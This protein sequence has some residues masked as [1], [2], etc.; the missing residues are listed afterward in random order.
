MKFVRLPILFSIILALT[1]CASRIVE[2]EQ[3]NTPFERPGYT[4]Y[5]PQDDG[6]LFLEFDDTGKH[7]LSFNRP[8][9]EVDHTLY[10]NVEEVHSRAN[11][12]NPEDFLTFFKNAMQVGYD[13]RR[14]NTIEEEIKL[15][16]KFGDFTIF[17]YSKIEDH[18]A[19]QR[20]G[21]PFLVMETNGYYF[22]HPSIENL[23]V[24]VT[25]S[26]RAKDG[27]LD[28]NFKKNA[29]DFINGLKVKQN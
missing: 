28:S 4:I 24:N 13:P 18:S 23:I 7:I 17:H 5:S 2:I 19:V 25:Y 14:F 8:Q 12:E 26:E 16:N 21:V 9:K 27:D 22:V 3:P 11:F 1:G 10:A 20:S 6:W 29:M 15:E